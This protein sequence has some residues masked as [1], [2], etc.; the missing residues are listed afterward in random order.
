MNAEHLRAFFWLHWRLRVNRLKRGGIGNMV[1]LALLA[2]G[3]VILAGLLFVIFFLIAF[4]EL[5]D[6]APAI[7]M[8]VWDG[9]ILGFLMFWMIGIV[10]DLQRAEAI[11][12]EKFLHLPVSLAGVFL[13]NYLSSLLSFTLILFVPAMAGLS[14]GL[15]LARGPEM[16]LLAPLVVAF[17]FMVT[18]VTYQFRGWL[19]SLMVN[20]RRRRT[21]IVVV[22]MVFILVFQLPNLLN[23]F[24]P[25]DAQRDKVTQLSK[26]YAD[27]DRAL[28]E[29]EITWEEHQRKRK[30]LS[31][32]YK[33]KN[34]ER[35]RELFQN[36]EWTARIVN[37]ALPPGWL[38]WGALGAAEGNGHFALLAVLGM[39]LLGAASLRRAYRTT[40]RLYTGQFTAGQ[41][42]PQDP[43]TATPSDVERQAA[44]VSET[45]GAPPVVY[46]G[47]VEKQLP[48]MSEH[49]SAIAVAGLRSLTR[50][51]EVKMLLLTPVFLLVIFGATFLRGSSDMHLMVRPLVAAGVIAMI[52]F[53]FIQLVGNQFGFDRSGFRVFV[54][55]P[56]PRRDILIGKNLAI[57]PLAFIMSLLMIVFVQIVYP[58]RLDHLVS[59]LPMM[60]SMYLLFCLMGNCLSILAPMPIAA[61]TLKPSNSRMLPILLNFAFLLAM[62]VALS[63]ALL[64]LGLEV[65]FEAET[66][67]VCL[68]L[69]VA[70]CAGLVFLYRWI[71]G[72]QGVWL[73]SSEQRILEIVAAKAE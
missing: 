29:K 6:A 40:L 64:P 11:S 56:A 27:L 38:A 26:D 46:G 24:R 67:P 57:A 8:F 68:V 10:T 35:N 65:W 25:W 18:A 41:K 55:G 13:L 49:V 42:K 71:V 61:G 23:V 72:W 22:T 69:S 58:M 34:E 52:L 36:A 3:A 2:A 32:G 20:K 51:P 5:G 9:L 12:L 31:E 43:R 16:L 19:A 48:W 1:V 39:G 54:L 45:P 59:V 7:I 50:A 33:A 37:L 66:L 17:L 63:P 62:P 60:V 53:S 44:G 70:E 28:K 14:L 47:L 4:H 73:Q 15:L 30:E 21:I